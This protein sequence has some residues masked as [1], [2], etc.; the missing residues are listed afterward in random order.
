MPKSSTE[1]SQNLIWGLF[2]SVRLTIVLLIIL[3]IASILG[4]II[5]QKDAAVSLAKQLS[6]GLFR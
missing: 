2:S 4:T 6:P 3:A 1:K 5:P